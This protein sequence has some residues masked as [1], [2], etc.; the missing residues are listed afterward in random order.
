MLGFETESETKSSSFSGEMSTYLGFMK[1]FIVIMFGTYLYFFNIP[2]PIS[3][4]I[5]GAG[6]IILGCIIFLSK[7]AADN[8]QEERILAFLSFFISGIAFAGAFWAFLTGAN[9]IIKLIGFIL[10]VIGIFQFILIAQHL[11]HLNAQIAQEG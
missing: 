10:F 1:A 9:P 6:L 2:N 11:D 3:K 8:T 5:L 7:P 4:I